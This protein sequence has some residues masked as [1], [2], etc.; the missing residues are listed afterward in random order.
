MTSVTGNSSFFESTFDY[1]S[2]LPGGRG[3]PSAVDVENETDADEPMS[4]CYEM[5]LRERLLG[6]GTCMIA[7]YL[8]SM[9]SFWRISD[10]VVRHDPFPFVV[11]ATVG[12]RTGIK[13]SYSLYCEIAYLDLDSILTLLKYSIPTQNC[14]A[15][16]G[17]FFL[18]GV[19]SIACRL[20]LFLPLL[21]LK[22]L[23]VSNHC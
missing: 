17:S 10:L 11:H 18:M 4:L 5:S 23:D 14:L 16:A 7:G 15:L 8:L 6:C 13:A 9:G 2:L 12:V 1:R 20:F 3:A 22:F 21:S 19:C